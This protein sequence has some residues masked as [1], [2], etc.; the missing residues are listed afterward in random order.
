MNQWG[1]WTDRVTCVN[2]NQGSVVA[3][4]AN[5]PHLSLLTRYQFRLWNQSTSTEELLMKWLLYCE[6]F[7]VVPKKHTIIQCHRT[8]RIENP[9]SI[10][11][12][13]KMKKFVHA[14]MWLLY[15]NS[16]DCATGVLHLSSF[17]AVSISHLFHLT[18]IFL[19]LYSD[20]FNYPL[21]SPITF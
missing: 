1:L 4:K 15:T 20:S 12:Q 11:I 9:G 8:V 21:S 17:S 5:R 7:Q 16:H 2:L 3:F 19:S 13:Y 18:L 10:L 6:V 14:F